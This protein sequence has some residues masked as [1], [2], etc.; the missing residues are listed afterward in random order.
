[1]KAAALLLTFQFSVFSLTSCQDFFDTDSTHIVNVEDAQ[2]LDAS[3]TI[4]SMIGVL[5]KMQA[6]ADRTVLLG[7]VRGDLMNI[8]ANTSSD[9]RDVALFQ[10]GDSNKYNSPRD[11]YA[12]IN[13]CNLYISK[14]DTTLE[15]SH[16]KSLFLNE[17]AAIKAIRAWTY[18]QLV[19]TYGSVPFVPEPILTKE[20]GERDYPR[21]D[22]QGICDYFLNED[23]L[24]QLA[25]M[26]EV[27]YPWYGDI[28]GTPSQL[29][30]IPLYVILGDLNLWAGNY[31]DAAKCYYSYLDTRNKST[32]EGYPLTSNIV[33]WK[34]ST[35][36]SDN[37]SNMLVTESTA[38][39]AEVISV[40]PMDSIESE[41]YYSEL[42][43]LTNSS[44]SDDY[45]VSL[46]PSD[47]LKALSRS[48]TNVRY[49][50]TSEKYNTVAAS[51]DEYQ[52]DLRLPVEYTLTTG[53]YTDNSGK[54]I[55]GQRIGKFRTSFGN[56]H[57]YRR[58]LVYLR[59]AEALN[60]AGYP[61]F[62][63][64]I[65]ATGVDNSFIKKNITPYYRNDSTMLV[66]NFAFP[67]TRYSV[68]KPDSV[69][70][71]SQMNHG[72]VGIHER[73][74]GWTGWVSGAY[75]MPYNSN[76]TDSLQQIAWQQ[77][78]VED[79]IVD[80]EAL[81]CAFEGYRYYDLLRVALR[82]F[83]DDPSYLS[84]KIQNRNNGLATGIKADLTDKNNWFIKWKGQIGY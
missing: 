72:M 44:Y 62:A 33:Q 75:D 57:I 17:Y 78:Q 10:V 43:G 65:L 14:A 45:E 64:A 49:D 67:D 36:A 18:L 77:E 58:G 73:G 9:L 71:V 59:L 82:R 56:I 69:Y 26:D 4:Y 1:M 21:K 25:A 6:I 61:R 7:E 80:E 22:I 40:I 16:G 28:K 52:G 51:T 37:W 3:D 68:M 30:Y 66:S 32:S 55:D 42:R 47:Y 81:E 76:I 31:L 19:T 24:Q 39:Y 13:M 35:A 20:E 50:E 34:S 23:G 29:F 38:K 46:V 48:Q 53:A 11:Y 12:I 8:N 74:C 41:G 60:R 2:L 70:T 83:A 79:M 54:K 84:K 15:D 63:Y 27:T 5:N